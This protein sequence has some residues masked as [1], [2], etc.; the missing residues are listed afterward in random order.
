MSVVEHV[1][2]FAMRQV[3]GEG[4]EAAI[5]LL[6]DQVNDRSQALNKALLAANDRAWHALEVAL[7]GEG[8]F[9][10][11][12]KAED[13]GLREQMRKFIESMPMPAEMASRPRLKSLIL[14][15][16][17]DARAKKVLTGK[18]EPASLAQEVGAFARYSNPQEILAAEKR[19][20]TNLARSMKQAG[21]EKL[22]WLLAQPA[23][24]QDSIVVA[25]ARY[26]FRAEVE[27]DERLAHS[28]QISAL[29][30]L[31]ASQQSSFAGIEGMLVQQAARLDQALVA[32][33][34]QMLAAL[35]EVKEQV[36]ATGQ[37]L[38]A[39][40]KATGQALEAQLEEVKSIQAQVLEMVRKL[41]MKGQPLRSGHT[42]SINNEREK[43]LVREVLRRFR[44]LPPSEQN[45]HP[46]L[47]NDLGKLQVAAGELGLAR[48][49]FARAAAVAP[50]TA[51]R[52]E[53]HYNAYRA[54]LEQDDKDQALR[55][56]L[57]AVA[58]DPGRFAPFP[59]EDYEALRIL[60]A[61]GFGVTLLARDR[62]SKGQVA[63]KSLF[64]E[65]LERDA[66]QVLEEATTLD[67][68]KHRSIIGLRR[69]GYVDRQN[70]RRP[71]LVMEYFPG[72]TLEEHVQSSGPLPF[73]SALELAVRMAEALE[74]A[75]GM[76]VLHR[77][78]KPANVL[79]RRDGGSWDVRIIDF[80]LAMKAERLGDAT[81]TLRQSRTI[82]GSSIAGT[83]GFAAPEQM[84][85]LPGERVGA[86]ADIYG[87]GKTLS[88]A[89]FGITEPGL[90]HYRKLPEAFAELLSRCMAH[91]PRERPRS[92][93]EVLAE[94]RR[95]Q[96]PP[97]PVPQVPA[98]AAILLE[99]VRPAR[100]AP[101]AVPA[102]AHLD[103]DLGR[104][105]RRDYDDNDDDSPRRTRTGTGSI[106]FASR[107]IHALLAFFPLTSMLGIH[108]FAQGNSSAGTVRL[109]ICLTCI[110]IYVNIFVGF[111]EG[112][113]FLTRNDQDYYQVYYRDM[114]GW[115]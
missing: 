58:L 43:S 110:G 86:P 34:A 33:S 46:E 101:V 22:A 15:E 19:L 1:C 90:Q 38:G 2:C 12:S 7:A 42:L 16:V 85:K 67:H 69:C 28:L 84:G 18:L 114:K 103:E 77:D 59:I 17:R 87:F 102:F 82:I 64:T 60:G 55:E 25:A 115:F 36:E 98:E 112:V 39:Q 105:R 30:G 32:V 21:Y 89:L 20:L 91:L 104:Q 106:N 31:A 47:I 8:L 35:G 74:A 6:G 76:K 3:I 113:V 109:L 99:E 45:A 79:I 29:E 83:L 107:L 51:A 78:I 108:K 44:G 4:A 65:D 54:A 5:R 68:I 37:A 61:G 26:Y 71:Y 52:A 72:A 57:Q 80:G 81:S 50:D 97:P 49:M 11:F 9:S 75:H 73:D 23:H 13:R 88:F 111:I 24:A 41:D 27:R 100:P 62:F 96:A 95:C 48:E 66:G 40:V 70:L 93:T 53:A 14:A 63:I 10:F 56:L 92:F 94:L